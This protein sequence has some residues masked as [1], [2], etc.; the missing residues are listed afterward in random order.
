[1]IYLNE[2]FFDFVPKAEYFS[3]NKAVLTLSTKKAIIGLA[4]Y[5]FDLAH[6]QEIIEIAQ[7]KTKKLIVYIKEPFSTDLLVLLEKF[8]SIPNIFFF[9]DAVIN[10]PFTNW[11]PA[12]S[13]FVSPRHY[14]QQDDWA[15]TLLGKVDQTITDKPYIFDCLLGIQRF[16]RD[17]IESFIFKSPHRDKCIYSYYKND[18]HKGIW[19]FDIGNVTGTWESVRVFDD[20]EV[21]LSSLIPYDIYNQSHFSIVAETTHFNEF[22]HFTEKTAKPI[23]AK[24][25][26][27]PFA[28]Q[29]FLSS[30][31]QLGFKTF[32]SIIDE[33][34]DNESNHLLRWQK[35]WTQVEYLCTQNPDLMRTSVQ[36]ILD[37]NSNHFLTSDWHQQVKN[38]LQLH[39]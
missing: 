3:D 39:Q 29:N 30:L 9:G 6:M 33:S 8:K 26:F 37:H 34:F 24:R 23:M 28:G 38:Y 1:M 11:K 12:F 15:K 7:G 16:N 4:F 36:E 19:N 2:H 32:S 27:V 35:A 31:Q 17:A 20:Y 22:N 13:W 25:I 14:Y 10:R 18:I 21:A 5:K